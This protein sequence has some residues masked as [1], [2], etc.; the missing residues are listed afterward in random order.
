MKSRNFTYLIHTTVA[1]SPFYNTRINSLVGC[2]LGVMIVC[3]LYA[4]PFLQA[5][6]PYQCIILANQHFPLA[7]YLDATH[8]LKHLRHSRGTGQ[9]QIQYFEGKIQEKKNIKVGMAGSIDNTR[10]LV[11]AILQFESS[12][13]FQ[14]I[15]TSATS[16]LRAFKLHSM[17]SRIYMTPIEADSLLIQ[18]S[19]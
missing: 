6:K 10:S 18:Q 14:Q 9:E 5:A 13:S 17:Q 19:P 8:Y 1:R 4:I 12:A 2:A 3:S 11:V 7:A 15:K 16:L